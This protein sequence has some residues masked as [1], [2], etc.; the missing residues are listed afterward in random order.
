MARVFRQQYTR[1]IP[2]GAQRV[3]HKGRPAVRF[4]GPDGKPVVAPLTR[5]GDRCRVK[6]PFW[7]G[8]VRYPDGSTERVK[9][10]ENKA[11][12]EMMLR[13]KQ[14]EADTA[15]AL[16]L[17]LERLTAQARPLSEHLEDY[18]RELAARD[19]APRYVAL[20]VSRLE[21]LFA[22][23]G[24]VLPPDLSPSRAMDWLAELRK[25][26]RPR[27]PLPPGKDL[28]TAKEVAW[29][30]GITS[31]SVGEAARLAGVA[32]VRRG[33]RRLYPP[34]S[35][36]ALQDRRCQGVSV[37]TTNYYLSH[38]KSFGRWMVQEDR[39]A[40]NPFD[41]LEGGN[42]TVDRRHDRRELSA[43]ELRRL[44]DA[45][46]ASARPFLG[47]TGP[48]RFH[49]YATACATG[50][51]AS[52]LASLKPESF[53]LAGD[54]PT[55]TLPARSN[56]SRKTKVQPDPPRR[57]GAAQGLPGW[58]ARRQA[59]LGRDVGAGL[60]GRGDAA[61]RPGGGRHPLRRRGARRSPV[62]RLPRPAAHLPDAGG[63]G[64]H[65]PADAP[66]AGRPF[67]ADPHRPLL[68]PPP[69]RPPGGRRKTAKHDSRGRAGAAGR[70]P[71]ADRQ[72]GN[73]GPRTSA[74]LHTAYTGGLSGTI[75]F[76][77]DRGGKWEGGREAGPASTPG[78]RRG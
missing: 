23:C 64:R 18:G 7:Y 39:M 12:A 76:E 2:E 35:V 48:D 55:V 9:L 42:A 37:Q 14:G 72:R 22:G 29:L 38:L 68:P 54:A 11:A 44:L 24:F 31:Q 75:L 78:L 50:F 13:E 65:R 3:T 30:L 60:Q 45:T 34:A 59:R 25:K 57:G 1:P 53:D 46:R 77:T 6:S 69:V 62:R 16:G 52:A 10:C 49:L 40:A 36:E 47:L 4:P 26:G 74:C 19:N 8:R 5:K 67:D 43:D 70:R 56:K 15:R 61:R 21:A 41:R 20:V 63:P 66:G 27:A 32:V 73:S 28:F 17:P 51:R 33:K 71:P 58:Q